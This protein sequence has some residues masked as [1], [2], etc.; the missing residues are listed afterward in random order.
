MS[1]ISSSPNDK[2][3]PSIAH[4]DVASFFDRRAKRL[5]ELGPLVTVI[6]QDKHPDL[7]KQ[8]DIAEKERL[9]PLL[10]LDGT[11]RILD[12]GCGTGRWAEV[13]SKAGKW[14]HGTDFNEG[15]IK[16][17]QD[18]F[19]SLSNVK[20][21]RVSI[22][23]LSLAAIEETEPFDLILC[24]GV[25]IYLND[26]EVLK[27]FSNFSKV[28]APSSRIVIREPMGVEKRLTLKDHYS[29]DMEQM[30]NAV[31]RTMEELQEMMK[32]TL[33]TEGFSLI[34]RG[35]MYE[36][37]TLNNRSETRQKWMLLERG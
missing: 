7:A 10:Q 37:Q 28:V 6:Y 21:T 33:F 17:A 9:L 13:L 1:R 2:E 14:Y 32:Q 30:Y 8:R 26:E 11:Q 34:E 31:Y 29:E 5:G 16:Y 4:S 18:H 23:D 25:L 20:F 12:V 3:K 22:T 15:L 35:N 19:A 36:D 24:A 27:A